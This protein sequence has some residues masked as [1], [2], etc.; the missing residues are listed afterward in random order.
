MLQSDEP[1]IIVETLNGY[2]LKE[3]QPDNLG[4][5]IVPVGKIEVTKEGKMLPLVTYGSTW[6]LVMEAAEELENWE[7]LRKLLIFSL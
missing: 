6:R 3:K 2:R 4:E 1:A 5:F 7:F